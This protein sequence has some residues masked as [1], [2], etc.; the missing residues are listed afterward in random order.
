MN[1]EKLK[2]K[3]ENLKSFIDYCLKVGMEPKKGHIKNKIKELE[4][5]ERKI[6]EF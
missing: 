1:K 5:V 3:A 4:E 6:K 2:K